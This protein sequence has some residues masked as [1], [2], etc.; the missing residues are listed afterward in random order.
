[1]IPNQHK[2]IVIKSRNKQRG[3][4]RKIDQTKYNES[5]ERIFGK[6]HTEKAD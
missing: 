5:W 4:P 2:R 3:R 6:K 1:M